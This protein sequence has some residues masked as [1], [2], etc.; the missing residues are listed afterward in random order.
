MSK[1]NYNGDNKISLYE[2]ILKYVNEE[3]GDQADKISDQVI[4]YR[5][6]KNSFDKHESFFK[7]EHA[8]K[9]LQNRLQILFDGTDD[10]EKLKKLDNRYDELLKYQNGGDDENR[11]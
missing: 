5:R 2:Q 9:V 11:S 1:E 10:T 3:V 6:C 4:K 7:I 8:I